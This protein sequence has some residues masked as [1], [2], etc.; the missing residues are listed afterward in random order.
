MSCALYEVK[1]VVSFSAEA[2]EE[3]EIGEDI[4][5]IN[6]VNY[7]LTSNSITIDP[8]TRSYAV[9]RRLT[10]TDH[11]RVLE[12]FKLTFDFSDGPGRSLL[13]VYICGRVPGVR[14]K[15]GCSREPSPPANIPPNT[16]HSSGKK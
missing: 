13:E 9:G 1:I 4:A 16:A 2:S 8:G 11:M 15:Q 7:S 5:S 10:L 6:N 14:A 12:L 3:E